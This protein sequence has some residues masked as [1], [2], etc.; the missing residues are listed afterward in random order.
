[1]AG[2][3]GL[4]RECSSAHLHDQV[5]GACQG[6]YPSLIEHRYASLATAWSSAPT[7]ASTAVRTASVCC[8]HCWRHSNGPT[9]TSRPASGGAIRGHSCYWRGVAVCRTLA[10]DELAEPELERL[11]Q[12][13]D[14]A[15]R[16]TAD[17]LPTNEAV[18][19]DRAH[20]RQELVLSGLD[21]LDE[22]P[23]L[24]AL[25]TLVAQRFPRV[26]L[27]ELLL[28]VQ[29]WTGFASDF[30]H[31]NE[32]GARADDL[33]ISVCAALLAEARNVGLEP[34]VRPEVP[35]LK[36]ARLA[37]IQ[38]NYLRADTI[39]NANAHLV[40]AHATLPL[41]KALG[42][43]ELASADGLRFVVPVRSVHAAANPKFHLDG[44]Y[45]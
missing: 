29:A 43:T 9:C 27:P 36:R 23:S 7:R 21:K 35:A 44:R 30:T 41:T 32:H 10:R 13:L 28:E 25:R 45:L 22:P 8:R 17:N 14:A 39:T 20:G 11:K 12:E 38:Q 1:M 6:N 33:P 16:R 34:L 3:D 24:L 26:E 18:H 5:G 2:I 40:D 37:W 42:S 15:Y 31:V 19:I 4:K